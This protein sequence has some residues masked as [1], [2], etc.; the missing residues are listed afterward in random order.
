[1]SFSI[2]FF[3]S[4]PSGWAL[5]L[6]QC[7]DLIKMDERLAFFLKCVFSQSANVGLNMGLGLCAGLSHAIAVGFFFL[8]HLVKRCK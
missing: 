2:F 6:C 8:T 1:M 7:S 5:P 4:E 3:L